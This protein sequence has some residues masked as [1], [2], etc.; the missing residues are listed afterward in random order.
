MS[1]T[2]NLLRNAIPTMLPSVIDVV[3]HCSF[4]LNLN[5][6][7]VEDCFSYSLNVSV[8]VM[9][10]SFLAVAQVVLVPVPL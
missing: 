4:I 7:E 2:I 3:D 10:G 6:H 8:N 1:S 5:V 9:D